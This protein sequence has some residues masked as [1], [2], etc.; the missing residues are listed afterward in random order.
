[1]QA[2][3]AEQL[4]V[5]FEDVTQEQIADYVEIARSDVTKGLNHGSLS[6]ENL[7]TILTH[8]RWEWSD[9]PKLP[10][11]ETRTIAGYQE[12]IQRIRHQGTT[13]SATITKAEFLSLSCLLH[14][15]AYL[16]HEANETLDNEVWAQILNRI[17]PRIAKLLN[18]AAEHLPFRNPR[19]FEE[20]R[21]K[22]GDAVARC[23]QAIPFNW[24]E[25]WT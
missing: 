9:L 14:D 20:L 2:H 13:R 16:E 6:L 11:L 21:R 5:G 8:F 10:D 1:V 22:W 24:L 3:V 4:A 17:R 25:L 23:L 7:V 18:L 12:A 15:W 19:D